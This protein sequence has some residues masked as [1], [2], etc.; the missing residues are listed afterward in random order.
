MVSLQLIV[1]ILVTY[2]IRLTFFFSTISA[3]LGLT[4]GF[5]DVTSSE[6]LLV[7]GDWLRDSKD[8]K[9]AN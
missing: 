2:S 3:S 6:L 8:L 9:L 4:T 7:T 1:S 5:G